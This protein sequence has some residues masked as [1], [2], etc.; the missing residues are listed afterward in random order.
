MDYELLDKDGKFRTT[1]DNV[2]TFCMGLMTKE[3][4][5]EL[6]E[7]FNLDSFNLENF[8]KWASE[9]YTK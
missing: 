9:I 2:I 7:A 6:Y 8:R 4:L 3:Q 1:K 5:S